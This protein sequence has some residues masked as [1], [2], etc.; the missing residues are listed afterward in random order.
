MS[1]KPTEL[2]IAQF[3]ESTGCPDSKFVAA[4]LASHNC[5]LNQAINDYMDKNLA[6]KFVANEVDLVAIFSKYKGL[7]C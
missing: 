6:S 7:W 4:H 2:Q 5:N 3:I 1:K